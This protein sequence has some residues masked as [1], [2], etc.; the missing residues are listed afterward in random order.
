MLRSTAQ[1]FN[2]NSTGVMLDTTP[3]VNRYRFRDTISK[4]PVFGI[5]ALAPTTGGMVSTVRIELERCRAQRW[6]T[7]ELRFRPRARSSLEANVREQD[8]WI[9]QYIGLANMAIPMSPEDPPAGIVL[10][11]TGVPC[12]RFAN[13]RFVLKKHGCMWCATKSHVLSRFDWEDFGRADA[14]ELLNW[15]K[16]R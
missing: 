10:R 12:K 5:A 2:A 15:L 1:R 8:R 11:A 13:G 3:D 6:S 7:R 14:I 4:N 9:G 16:P